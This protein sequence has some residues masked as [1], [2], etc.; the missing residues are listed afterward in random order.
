MELVGVRNHTSLLLSKVSFGAARCDLLTKPADLSVHEHVAPFIWYPDDSDGRIIAFQEVLHR[1][2]HP[3]STSPVLSEISVSG[4]T[5]NALCYTGH[6]HVSCI[7][8]APLPF[9]DS[10]ICSVES[11]NSMWQ[12]WLIEGLLERGRSPV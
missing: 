12:R 9:I 1:V 3:P 6:E 4:S 11:D 5:G 8:Y 2:D 7:A 10:E